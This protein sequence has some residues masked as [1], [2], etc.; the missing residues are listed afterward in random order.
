M[1]LG[2]VELFRTGIDKQVEPREHLQ[3]PSM[4]EPDYWRWRVTRVICSV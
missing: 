2:E 4:S 1:G 3:C